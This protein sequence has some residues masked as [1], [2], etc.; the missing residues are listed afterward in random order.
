MF[1]TQ[2]LQDGPSKEEKKA[3]ERELVFMELR[4]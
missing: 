4:Q 3:V 1:L 2:F